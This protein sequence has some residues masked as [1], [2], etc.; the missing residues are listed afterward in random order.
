MLPRMI[1]ALLA[2]IRDID[3]ETEIILVNDGSDDDSLLVMKELANLHTCIKIIDLS[4]NFGK[5]YAV[6]AGLQFA[7]GA[8]AVV[9]DSDLQ[10]PP[11]VIPR[12]LEKWREGY[13]IAYGV[14]MDRRE[15]SRMKK[16]FSGLFYRLFNRLTETPI[17]RNVGDFLLLDRRVVDSLNALP[18][19]NRFMKG[20]FAWVGFRR[21]EVEYEQAERALGESKWN[22]W[23]LWNFALDGLTGFTTLP[24]R[25][26]S[27]VGLVVSLLAMLYASFLIVRTLIS[28]VDVP[29]FA[30]LIVVI[31]MLGGIQLISL[32]V[33]GEYLGRLYLEVKQRPLFLVRS[34]HGFERDAS[35]GSVVSEPPSRQTE[36]R[37]SS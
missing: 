26:W 15:E 4:R 32:G 25:L 20:L 37:R 34:T 11:D 6:S 7:R 30:T 35:E 16:A 2:V 36:P 9:M 10:H 21:A 13:D 27:Y 12:F 22:L 19:R 31:L 24:L 33:L 28:G 5:E 18:E 23:K 1:S 3:L 17:P 8:A 14:H 29:G